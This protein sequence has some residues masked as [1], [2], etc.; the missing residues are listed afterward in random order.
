MR[1]ALEHLR[2]GGE[3]EDLNLEELLKPIK[4][5]KKKKPIKRDE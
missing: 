4:K 5:L 2:R 3:S 1:D